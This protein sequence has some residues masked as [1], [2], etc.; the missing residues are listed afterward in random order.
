MVGWL[1]VW[2]GLVS[3]GVGVG[4]IDKVE[5]EFWSVFGGGINRVG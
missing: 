5:I 2:N 3:R 1:F 4:K